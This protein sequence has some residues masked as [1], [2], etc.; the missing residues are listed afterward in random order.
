ML[1]VAIG[2]PLI[3]VGAPAVGSPPESAVVSRYAMTEDDEPPLGDPLE[4]ES[5]EE[6]TFEF[7]GNTP[8]PVQEHCDPVEEIKGKCTPGDAAGA[9]PE[10]NDKPRYS[11]KTKAHHIAAVP[12]KS[13]WLLPGQHVKWTTTREYTFG[14][15]VTAGAE[16]EAGVVFG[17]VKA[18]VDVRVAQSWKAATGWEVGDTNTKTSGYRAVLGNRGLK[19]TYTKTRIVPPCNARTTS[20]TVLIPIQGDLSIGRYKS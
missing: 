20:G 5:G 10:V 8:P 7:E 2:L 6:V 13:T 17:K 3:L 4:D 14:L 12:R 9:C 15:D 16:I 19:A 11:V 18:K 1:T